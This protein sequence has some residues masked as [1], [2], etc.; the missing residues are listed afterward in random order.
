MLKRQKP[1]NILEKV[2]RIEEIIKT[3]FLF[4]AIFIGI[5]VF[6]KVG[7]DLYHSFPS[8]EI[9]L[10]LNFIVSK[11]LEE[12]IQTTYITFPFFIFIFSII[13]FISS[14][15]IF[16]S[17][18]YKNI[19]IFLFI[20]F[21]AFFINEQ[22]GPLIEVTDPQFKNWEIFLFMILTSVLAT[23]IIY[24]VQRKITLEG[25]DTLEIYDQEDLDAIIENHVRV[26]S[27]KNKLN[28]KD[29]RKRKRLGIMMSAIIAI[30]IASIFLLHVEKFEFITAGIILG[31]LTS[32]LIVQGDKVALGLMYF[33]DPEKAES[34]FKT[35]ILARAKDQTLEEIDHTKEVIELTS[36]YTKQKELKLLMS[37]RVALMQQLEKK[38]NKKI[39]DVIK[40][41]D[42]GQ[43]S[44]EE[45]IELMREIDYELPRLI[46]NESLIEPK[47]IP[48]LDD[49]TTCEYS[50]GEK[51]K[52]MIGLQDNE[53]DLAAKEGL[54]L[55]KQKF[56]WK[57]A[58]MRKIR[59]SLDEYERGDYSEYGENFS[60]PLS[61]KTYLENNEYIIK[62][63]ADLLN[64]SIIKEESLKFEKLK[65]AKD[66]RILDFNTKAKSY[67]AVVKIGTDKSI[68]IL[69][70]FNSPEYF[71]EESF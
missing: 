17:R 71:V 40:Q 54:I 61:L 66:L 64:T 56:I 28:L 14:Y 10:N 30:I 53:L 50:L 36:D 23:A 20:V 70:I 24:F 52:K 34:I 11:L 49:S 60:I 65:G 35:Y 18:N 31:I 63:F 62:S 27:N 48:L 51:V 5:Y 29:R 69:G 12:I 1:R 46:E 68:L 55:P 9:L 37:M 19:F 26:R 21:L 39:E 47:S 67:C 58:N 3:T 22:F 2:K 6:F 15:R 16:S 41:I 4:W 8:Q 38:R 45:L 44:I 57:L 33:V 25:K 13:T 7:I 59:H 42:D 43:L 32:G